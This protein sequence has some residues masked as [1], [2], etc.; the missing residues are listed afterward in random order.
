[1]KY[2]VGIDLG[3]TTTKAVVLGEDG[4]VLGRGI[5]NSRSNYEVAC[6]VAL[7]EALTNSRFALVAGELDAAG[8]GSE[9]RQRLLLRLELGLREQQYCVQLDSLGSVIRALLSRLSLTAE[10]T[11]VEWILES[12]S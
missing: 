5:T 4:A 1:M 12:G 8:F 10:R 6:N 2:C 11:S 3:S 7:S 9:T